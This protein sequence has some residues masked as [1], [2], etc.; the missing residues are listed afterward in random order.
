[1]PESAT[2]PTVEDALALGLTRAEYE[3]VCEHQGRAPNQVELAMYS[4]LWSE[5]CAYKH[6]KRL[7]R[8]LP[9]EGPHVVMGPGENAGAV[10]VGGGLVCAFKVESH[11][12]PSAVE[13]FQG[14][15]TGVGGI[16]R[17]IFAIGARPIAVLDSLR[18]GEPSATT[19]AEPLRG[20]ANPTLPPPVDARARYLLD[21]AVAG[22]GHYGNSI[23]VPT[24]GGEVYF[25]GPYEHNC[26]VNAMALGLCARARLVRS[27]AAGVGNVVVLF[28]A[29]TGRDGIGGASVLASAELGGAD[30]ADDDKRPTVQVGDPFAEKKLLECSLELLERG[31]LVSLQDL[32]A[33]G[34]T[35]SASEMASK[36]EV[37]ID[38]DVAR[39]PLREPGMEPFEIMV[40]ESQERMLCVVAPAD[41][42]AVLALCAKWEV[43][44][45]AI[46]TVTDTRRMRIFDGELLV[47][48]MPV[49][50]L[51]DDCP[52][53]DLAPARPAEPIYPAPPVVL[54]PDASPREALLALLRS[55]NIASRRPL[56]EQYDAI[57]QSRTVRRPEQADA[58]VLALPDGGALA[59]S[60]DCNG[61]RVA[62]DPYTGTVEAVLECAA[63]LACVGA[64]PLGTTNNLNFGNPEKPHIAWQLAES[65]RGLGDACRALEAPIVGGNVSLYNEGPAG[66]IYPTPV[67]GMVGRLPDAA[68][69]GRMGFAHA[70]DT[71]AVVGPFAPSPAASEWAKLRGE[72]LP[73]GL[74]AVDV[75]AVR[76]AQFAVRG[77]VRV[78]GLSSAHDIAEGGLAV[79][80]AECCLAGEVGAEIALLLDGASGR[81]GDPWAA[82]FGEGPGGFLLSGTESGVRALGRRTPVRVIGTVGGSTLR[83]AVG[84]E[85][86][87]ATLAELAEA[88]GA[89]AELFP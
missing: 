49:R 56:F 32:G 84:R 53:Y 39:V 8:T 36:G 61:R 66:P 25:E 67:V 86:V 60:I 73:D 22:I 26:L 80:L 58:A 21:G 51:V 30:G 5:H 55:P 6:S 75:G 81:D 24:V 62:A 71:I 2:L 29:S 23:G 34:L 89:L 70:G 4:L 63:N 64:E 65:V 79:A 57:V 44:G 35:S 82:L 19:T 54:P 10:D 68:R 12:H 46:G 18:F 78:G 83:I 88:H 17:D 15:A 40:S 41:V 52:L 85:R 59:I 76:A 33:A 7:L 42:P 47:G 45:T 27:A 3:L 38:I 87:E 69:A 74:P 16:L 72:P 50:A 37:G 31:L 28:G 14:A 9:T 20:G 77:A 13:P 11:N 1:V 48:E 43:G